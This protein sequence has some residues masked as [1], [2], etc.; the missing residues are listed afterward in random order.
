M[1]L[2]NSVSLSTVFKIPEVKFLVVG[3]AAC[4]F[5]FS[6]HFIPARSRMV[7]STYRVTTSPS[8]AKSGSRVDLAPVTPEPIEVY[9]ASNV[10]PRR[11]TTNS[12]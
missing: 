6:C 2:T 9:C 1:S 8:P 12:L 7:R 5:P 3:A 4:E 10:S 11:N